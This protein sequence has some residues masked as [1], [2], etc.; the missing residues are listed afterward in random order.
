ML[1]CSN[2]SALERFF[3]G[4]AGGYPELAVDGAKVL[5]HGAGAEVRSGCFVFGECVLHGFFGGHRVAFRPGFCEACLVQLRACGCHV[6]SEVRGRAG[7]GCDLY[8]EGLP[9]GLLR[10]HNRAARAGCPPEAE[11]IPKPKREYCIASL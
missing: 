10:P 9:H 1:N 3:Y 7:K 8:S 2:H 4:G 11:T 6:A 5:A